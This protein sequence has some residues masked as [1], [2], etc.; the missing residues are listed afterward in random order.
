LARV[1]LAEIRAEA[2]AWLAPESLTVV[3]VGDPETARTAAAGLQLT[4]HER[5]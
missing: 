3:V 1:S 5:P 2:R 4:L